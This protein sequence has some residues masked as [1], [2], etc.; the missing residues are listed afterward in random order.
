MTII[1]LHSACKSKTAEPVTKINIFDFQSFFNAEIAV[2]NNNH[3]ALI[4]TIID[5][6]NVYSNDEKN[7]NWNSELLAFKTFAY[8]KPQQ[9]DQYDVDTLK[10]ENGLTFITY[11][12]NNEQLHLQ[13]AEVMYNQNNTIE[14]ITLVVKSKSKISN[15]DM[16]LTYLPQ[17]GYDIKGDVN[18]SVAGNHLIDIHVSCN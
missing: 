2:L 18:S 11:S 15:N 8:I 3:V 7:P 5:R 6:E 9:R 12:A 17:K 4:K 13:L 1:C 14:K 16:T 10:S